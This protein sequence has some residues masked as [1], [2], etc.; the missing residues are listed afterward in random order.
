M[1]LG[2]TILL[3]VIIYV[4]GTLSVF[5]QEFKTEDHIYATLEKYQEITGKKISRFDEAPMLKIK[6]AAGELPPIE[7]R[8]P[9]EPMVVKPGEGI[10]KYG[11]TVNFCV[12]SIKSNEDFQWGR[13]AS[14]LRRNDTCSEV[15]P[16][17]I[18]GYDASKDYKVFTLYFRKGLKWSDGH[19]FTVDDVLFWWEDV[20][21]NKELTPTVPLQ[22]K[23]G[24]E[25]AKF[26]KIDDYTLRI[27]FAKPNP[28]FPAQM[29]ALAQGSFYHPK[30]YLN[31]WHIKYNPD[32][33]KLAK[34]EGYDYWWEAFEFHCD[35]G[36]GISDP[37]LPVTMAWRLKKATASYKSWERNPYYWAVDTNGN[38][39]PYIDKVIVKVIP[40]LEAQ[41]MTVITGGVDFYGFAASVKDYPLYKANEKKGGY[42]VMLAKST[43]ATHNNIAFNLNHPD[44]V[45]RKIFQNVKFRRALSVAINREEIN[46]KLYF[47]KG[48]V[49]QATCHPDCSFYKKEW[50]EAWA[51]YDPELA[52]KLLDEIGLDKRDPEGYRL[53]PD[54]KRMVVTIEYWPREE[55]TDYLEMVKKYWEA[56]GIKTNLKPEE[57]SFYE[58]T[59]VKT[60]EHDAG[61]WQLGVTMELTCHY[62]AI[63]YYNQML[64]LAGSTGAAVKWRQWFDTGGK[65]GWEPPEDIKQYFEWLKEWYSTPKGTEKYI[66]L[67]QKIFDFHAERIFHI[68][69][70][71]YIPRP[72]IVKN[73]LRNV[74]MNEEYFGWDVH[75]TR[76]YLPE[77]WFLKR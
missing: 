67:A 70:I 11:G 48:V 52:N 54:G 3:S 75:W 13:Y 39:L 42:R 2:M 57:R 5:G 31:K 33:N 62:M 12:A 47:G 60:G 38:Q 20:I 43:A 32:A 72:I 1:K 69:A 29:S 49:R 8:L 45:K 9:R 59:R 6:V 51:Q 71:G 68:G 18:K 63:N 46:K 16:N 55:R 35:A 76:P 73:E 65:S 77:Q 21:L 56:V 25:P 27:H 14:L 10:G 36:P 37:N 7:K 66:E 19:P 34:K 50:A 64:G 23:L 28:T 53:R 30:H 22:W 61:V 58:A 41:K 17:F 44:P 26:E 24:N 40:D 4:L 74:S 15:L